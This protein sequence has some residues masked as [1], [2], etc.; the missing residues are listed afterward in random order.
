MRF[1]RERG[2]S[3]SPLEPWMRSDPR[4][5]VRERSESTARR[6]A[7]GGA[8]G[9]PGNGVPLANRPK[10]CGRHRLRRAPA[11]P[12][13]ARTSTSTT[14]CCRDADAGWPSSPGAAVPAVRDHGGA[15]LLRREGLR[16][17][18]FD[19]AA[20][21]CSSR[22]AAPAPTAG[23]ASTDAAQVTVSAINRNFP[24]RSARPGVARQPRHPPPQSPLGEPGF[25]RGAP[26]V[27][28]LTPSAPSHDPF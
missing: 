21:A 16:R 11:P 13:S 4:R 2:M 1:L 19:E 23:R 28:A 24:G 5:R 17:D 25:L 8:P 3:T 12:A 7:H 20:P 26:R 14:R 18:A 27:Q 6:S 15:R 22:R 9:D 10:R